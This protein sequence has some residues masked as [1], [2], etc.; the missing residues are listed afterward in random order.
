M[1]RPERV[2]LA[3]GAL[4]EA[5][6]AAGLTQGADAVAAAGQNLVW[7]SLM[8]DVPDQPVLGGIE[9][10]MQGDGQFHHAKSGA[11]V[12]SGHRHRVDGLS[13]QF[14]GNLPK[15]ALIEPP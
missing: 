8:A 13:A 7:I 6:Q 1:A 3:L 5:G 15:L 14:I 10:V 11:E 12:A 2:V 4:A 9:H